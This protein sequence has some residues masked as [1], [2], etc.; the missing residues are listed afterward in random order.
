M[1]LRDGCLGTGACGFIAGWL[2]TAWQLLVA[3][4]Q[5]TIHDTTLWQVQ[6]A[7]YY[8]FGG[9]ALG[10][11]LSVVYV[12]YRQQAQTNGDDVTTPK[13]NKKATKQS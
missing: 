4:P 13:R 12:A 9:K 1:V 7:L 2:V 10:L 8:A 5:V 3:H 11:A 6:T